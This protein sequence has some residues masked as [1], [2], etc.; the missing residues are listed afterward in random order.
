VV[1]P[2]P[3]PYPVHLLHRLFYV[4]GNKTPFSPDDESGA[5]GRPAAKMLLYFQRLFLTFVKTNFSSAFSSFF[6]YAVPAT[7]RFW[8]YPKRLLALFDTFT[9]L[10]LPHSTGFHLRSSIQLDILFHFAP[11]SCE[12]GGTNDKAQIQSVSFFFFSSWRFVSARNILWFYLAF[13]F[14]LDGFRKV[15]LLQL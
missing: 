1:H 13:E 8:C 5:E 7:I 10:N 14:S 4:K 2:A 9:K 15:S 6:S 11:A 3:R 12:T